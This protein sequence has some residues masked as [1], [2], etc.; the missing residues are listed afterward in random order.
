MLSGA[1]IS[2]GKTLEKPGPALYSPECVERL[3]WKFTG[4]DRFCGRVL[5]GRTARVLSKAG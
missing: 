5:K 1:M 4:V 2:M 3:P